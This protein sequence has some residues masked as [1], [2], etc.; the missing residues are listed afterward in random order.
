MARRTRAAV[1]GATLAGALRTFDTV[2]R[3]TPAAAATCEIV[4]APAICQTPRSAWVL[5]DL[6]VQILTGY[7][8]CQG[9][10]TNPFP[11]RYRGRRLTVPGQS[12]VPSRWPR[13]VRS[14]TPSRSYTP[15]KWL[16]TVRMETVSRSAIS[17]L[18]RPEAAR[19]AI[20]RWRAVRP[21]AARSAR[22]GVR[23]LI[24]PAESSWQSRAI[25]HA[26]VTDGW[27]RRGSPSRR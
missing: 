26:R 5:S 9:G 4:T 1:G 2:C 13:P 8:V 10:M 25:A 12:R 23:T 21:G 19:W 11:P 15:H 22:A 7:V 27:A 14:L 16:A 3:E 24:S 20:S 18:V 17:R 6:I